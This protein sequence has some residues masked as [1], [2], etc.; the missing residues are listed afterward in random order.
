MIKV[1]QTGKRQSMLDLSPLVAK[2]PVDMC[3]PAVP[4]TAV[5]AAVLGDVIQAVAV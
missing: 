5:A 3:R 1:G 2:Q 4:L